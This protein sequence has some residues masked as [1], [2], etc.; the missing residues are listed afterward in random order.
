MKRIVLIVAILALMVVGYN[1]KMH[2]QNTKPSVVETWQNVANEVSL[3]PFLGSEKTLSHNLEQSPDKFVYRQEVLKLLKSFSDK[4]Y[5]LD[6][7]G[8]L[9]MDQY[10]A[11]RPKTFEEGIKLSKDYQKKTLE[12]SK[13]ISKL[14]FPKEITIKGKTYSLTREKANIEHVKG[15]YIT[16]FTLASKGYGYATL[17]FENQESSV[18]IEMREKFLQANDALFK[19]MYNLETLKAMYGGSIDLD[20]KVRGK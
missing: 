10:N 9:L 15:D 20:R 13:D 8:R 3:V 17:Y 11:A 2:S 6:H 1:I 5:P 16:G 4:I 12:V 18:L 19:G 7:Q 14:E